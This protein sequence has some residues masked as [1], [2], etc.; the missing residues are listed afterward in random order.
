MEARWPINEMK[1]VDKFGSGDG[2][3]S[4][5]LQRLFAP[6]VTTILVLRFCVAA[7]HDEKNGFLFTAAMEWHKAADLSASVAP[8]ADR[9]W[10][11]WERIV[12]LPRHLAQPI[13]ERSQRTAQI[14]GNTSFRFQPVPLHATAFL[15][16]SR[17]T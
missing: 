6:A 16:S 9:C 17:N 4:W 10:R 2:Y 1:S 8:I 5:K 7:R 15:R 13:S 12:R 3:P 11:N 14:R